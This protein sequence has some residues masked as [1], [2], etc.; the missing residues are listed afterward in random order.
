MIHLKMQKIQISDKCT[1][2]TFKMIPTKILQYS[3]MNQQNFIYIITF[4]LIYVLFKTFL[5]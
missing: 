3:D 2:Q 5:E 1:V 4:Q